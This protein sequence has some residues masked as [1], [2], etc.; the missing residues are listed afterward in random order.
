[1]RD[2]PFLTE[3][4]FSQLARSLQKAARV[5]HRETGLPLVTLK[6]AQTLGGKIATIRGDSKWI[7]SSSSLLFA[8]RLR[9][10]HDALLVGVDTIIRDDPSLTV[11]LVKGE[12]P[13]R[14]I[15]DSRLRIPLESK[16]LGKRSAPS[17]I[18]AT[19]SLS[20]QRKSDRIIS[21]G[22]EVWHIRKDGSDRVNLPYLLQKL[23]K[24]DIRSILVEGG[25]LVL[26]SF[27]KRRL[28]DYLV[29]VIAPKIVGKGIDSVEPAASRELANLTSAPSL[30]YFRAGND[31][32]LTARVD[33]N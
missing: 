27:L 8:H 20:D 26:T 18:I 16:V 11:R 17:T 25:G 13:R 15:V 3:K 23:G 10:I 28:A 21:T 5:K 22:A 1:M 30:R 33:T 31:I 19:T 24:A 32:I 29:V 9:S 6:F 7:S 14:I 4:L 2:I 12:S